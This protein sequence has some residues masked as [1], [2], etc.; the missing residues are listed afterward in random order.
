MLGVVYVAV[1]A[2]DVPPADAAYH[3]SVLPD[4]AV[5]LNATVPVPHLAASVATGAAGRG[6]TTTTTG[7]NNADKQPVVR[8]LACA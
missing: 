1:V 7:L 2:S 3:A 6:F 5:A 8:F 4:V